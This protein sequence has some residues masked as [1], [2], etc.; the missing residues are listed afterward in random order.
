MQNVREL[1][2]HA[3]RILRRGVERIE[4]VDRVM[5]A[6]RDPRLH[7]HRREPV[8]L[9]PQLY[10]VLRAGKRCVGRVLVAEHQT[11]RDIAVRI[12]VPDLGRAVLGGILE[13]HHHRQRLVLDLDQL[14]SV[15][16]LR[17]RFGDH[18][19]HAVADIADAL[20]VQ[21]RLEGAVPFGRAEILGH[22][23]RGQRAQVI[24]RG[25]GAGQHREHTGCGLGRGGVDALDLGVGVRRQHRHAVAHAGQA[26]VVDIA[27]R[28]GQEPL[29]LDPPD[30]LS[31]AELGCHFRPR[32]LLP[33]FAN[34]RG[35]RGPA[36]APAHS[37]H[38]RG[39]PS[40]SGMSGSVS[41]R[42]CAAIRPI[43][44]CTQCRLRNDAASAAARS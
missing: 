2:A 43:R 30:S 32:L 14:G 21:D 20:G 22:R 13:I 15:A 25:V 1:H 10:D 33:D 17:H 3:V 37:S 18:E 44:T 7:R 23:M 31:D 26:D 34:F 36:P 19:C 16:R 8:A 40:P 4:I 42:R 35:E 28:T 6:D 41:S 9:D 5:V 12:V 24:G 39:K 27:P 29:I 11:E 38:W